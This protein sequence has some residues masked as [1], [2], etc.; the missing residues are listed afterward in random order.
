M[1]VLPPLTGGLLLF[2]ATLR[3]MA[4]A[5]RRALAAD[6]AL[7]DHAARSRAALRDLTA[8]GTGPERRGA[9]RSWSTR[10][11][12][13]PAPWPAGRRC[14][15]RRSV[16]RVSCPSWRCCWRCRGCAGGE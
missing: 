16:S 7:G 12:R 6:E 2:L 4:A 3:P 5:Q 10:P 15:R 13:R 11:P 14:A 1:V 9:A 8:C